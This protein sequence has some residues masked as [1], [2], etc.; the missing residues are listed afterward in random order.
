[1]VKNKRRRRRL[2]RKVKH[3]KMSL[4]NERVHVKAKQTHKQETS[5]DTTDQKKVTSDLFSGVDSL[6]MFCE[7]LRT[8]SL[9][10]R[11]WLSILNVDKGGTTVSIL[12]Q[13]MLLKKADL[14]ASMRGRPPSL[15]SSA[16]NMYVALWRTLGSSVKSKMLSHK[17]SI[18]TDGPTLLWI[19]LKM[20]QGTAAQVIR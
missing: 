3:L 1:M 2:L 8:E 4:T 13:Y 15:Q 20:Y 14:R 6:H 16:T 11:G 17:K 7:D 5:R 19:L 12:D 10:R 9:A 18:G